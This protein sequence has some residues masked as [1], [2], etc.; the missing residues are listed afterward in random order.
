VIDIHAEHVLQVP[1]VHDQEPVEALAASGAD[2]AL[3]D[4]VR[5]RRAHR[6]LDHLDAFAGE[7]GVKAAGEL[8]VAVADKEAE[9]RRLLL[10]CPGDL[11]GLLGDPGAGGV[12]GAA[13]E[14]DAAAS[15]LD[16]EENV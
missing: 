2:E 9:T 15:Q 10:E 16:E 3:G 13:G 14:V 1:M 12:G 6:C 7:D 5:L 4:R 8:G 11:A